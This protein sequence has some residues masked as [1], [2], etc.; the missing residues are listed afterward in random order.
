MGDAGPL[1]DVSCLVLQKKE[2]EKKKQHREFIKKELGKFAAHRRGRGGRGWMPDRYWNAC[3]DF[4]TLVDPNELHRQETLE[5]AR[6]QRVSS[7]SRWGSGM[8]DSV[9]ICIGWVQWW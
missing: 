1:Q 2:F 3:G 7:R 4:G 5:R 9:L 8:Y 6:M